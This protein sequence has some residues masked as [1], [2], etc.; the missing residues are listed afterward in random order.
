MV[1]RTYPG[2][3]THYPLLLKSFMQRAVNPYPHEIGMV[4]RN[5]I[6]GE[7]QRFT[8]LQWYQRT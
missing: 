6:S 1:D 7:Y 5:H 8:W 2:F 4:Y 3:S